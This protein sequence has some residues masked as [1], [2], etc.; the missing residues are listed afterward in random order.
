MVYAGIDPLTG[1]QRYLRETCATYDQAELALTR[2]QSQVDEDR[3][4][5][6]EITVG[7]AVAQWLDVWI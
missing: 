5:K 2:L 1:K 3:H 4:P 7:Q 6:S